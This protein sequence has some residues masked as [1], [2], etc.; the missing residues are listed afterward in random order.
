MMN[1]KCSQGWACV[2]NRAVVKILL[3]DLLL[4]I[5]DVKH[6]VCKGIEVLQLGTQDGFIKQLVGI[7]EHAGKEPADKSIG[8]AITQP[9]GGY[10]LT[11]VLEIFHRFEQPVI[12]QVLRGAFLG[13]H[14]APDFGDQ[15]TNVVVDADVRA[16]VSSS[17]RKSAQSRQDKAHERRVEIGS[18]S[19]RVEWSL[20][21]RALA[22]ESGRRRTAS[23]QR[24][25]HSP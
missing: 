4:G 16:D 17:G 21:Q 19:Q 14:S 18:H 13:S 2:F 1:S 20:G 25:D 8:D 10:R 9:S 6:S 11:V 22:A 23:R 24:R 15:Q 3:G 7:V 5:G 12:D